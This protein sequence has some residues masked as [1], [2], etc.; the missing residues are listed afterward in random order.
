MPSTN[1][2]DAVFAQYFGLSTNWAKDS[3][4]HLPDRMP[5]TAAPLQW[6]AI[7]LAL[8]PEIRVPSSRRT[9]IP[10]INPPWHFPFQT[11]DP[12]AAISFI[13]A[14]TSG[15]TLTLHPPASTKS[16]SRK[17]A[18]AAFGFAFLGFASAPFP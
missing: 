5:L 15:D 2:T 12:F 7:F 9:P 14:T 3:R 6:W 18:A 4:V 8:P 10:E 17:E 1:T 11:T 16:T 13:R